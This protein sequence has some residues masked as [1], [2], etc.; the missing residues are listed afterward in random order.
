[1]FRSVNYVNTDFI[2]IYSYSDIDYEFHDSLN[3][4]YFFIFVVGIV[5]IIVLFI[6]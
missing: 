2:H 4:S 1:M 5:V 6:L 3:S